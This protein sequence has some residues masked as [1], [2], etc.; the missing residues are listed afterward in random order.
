VS[1]QARLEE[2]QTQGYVRYENLPLETKDGH[3]IAVEFVS[4]VYQ[5]GDKKVIQCNIRDIT[6]RK[7]S[8]QALQKANR[9]K[10]EFLA[11]M[12]HE[13]RTPLNGIIGFS[14]FLIDEKPGKLNPKQSEYLKDV[15]NSAN[16]LLQLINDVL[17]LSKVEAGKM[18]L[19]PEIF[20]VLKAV[21]EVCAVIKGIAN[22]K[23]I[24]MAMEISPGLKAVQLD[25]QKFKQVLY[26]LLSNAVKFTDAG[27]KVDIVASLR[28][29]NQFQVVVKDTGIGIKQE[30]LK[31][32]FH[33]FEQL[34]A[35]TSRRFEGTGLGLALTKK[36][37]EFQQGSIDVQSEFGHGSTFTALFPKGTISEN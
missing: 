28:E 26:N 15:L 37:V 29:G 31:R 7:R 24:K 5:A 8:D 2:L 23:Q 1:N 32:L 3:N 19:H 12:S 17:D 25:L 14:E 27:G 11:N 9:M 34:D 4:N 35:G 16:H 36:I 18:E 21:E 22:K 33:E 13:L 10:S 30:D 6:E 20:S